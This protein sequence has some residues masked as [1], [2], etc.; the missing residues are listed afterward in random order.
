MIREH[1]VAASF[2]TRLKIEETER[3]RSMKPTSTDRS[4][5]G[6]VSSK[7]VVPG[8]EPGERKK[9]GRAG[10]TADADKSRTQ[11]SIDA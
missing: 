8:P 3:P 5:P 1:G 4:F 9:G 7:K 6:D 10:E 2:Q 11:A